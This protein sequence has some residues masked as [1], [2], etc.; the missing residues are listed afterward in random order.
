[1]IRTALDAHLEHAATIFQSLLSV[2]LQK[3]L[4]TAL[5]H[6][7][8]LGT[9][10]EYL[11]HYVAFRWAK[12]PSRLPNPFGNIGN[13]KNVDLLRTLMWWCVR[14]RREE[15]VEVRPND[16]VRIEF[17]CLSIGKR[18]FCSG[19]VHNQAALRPTAWRRSS[20]ALVTF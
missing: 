5:V 1:M 13:N 18:R 11:Y 19:C 16:P 14:A 6:Q 10:V 20:R 15:Y 8:R 2:P 4:L 12:E 9:D 17:S 7:L 3:P